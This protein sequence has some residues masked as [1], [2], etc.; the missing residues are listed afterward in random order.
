MGLLI[1]RK[2]ET[3]EP[4]QWAIDFLEKM[5]N[6]QS[7]ERVELHFWERLLKE[8]KRELL[9]DF[10]ALTPSIA[11]FYRG[12][13][14]SDG[15]DGGRILVMKILMGVLP[16]Y[17]A[18][19]CSQRKSAREI[20]CHL[21]I[22]REVI[23]YF[24]SL[25]LAD[26]GDRTFWQKSF[27]AAVKMLL[28]ND[29]SPYLFYRGGQPAFIIAPPYREKTAAC[30]FL[31]PHVIVLYSLPGKNMAKRVHLI[32]HEI[33]HLIFKKYLAD[34]PPPNTFL[35]LLASLKPRDYPELIR[36]SS[37]GLAEI[38]SNLFA[39]AI[40]HETEEG[41]ELFYKIYHKMGKT[42][43]LLRKAFLPDSIFKAL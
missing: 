23:A 21:Q 17:R 18:P 28:H 41:N 42:T 13:G 27:Y 24:K 40:M 8:K 43:L 6:L 3:I 39:L 1:K 38:F 15:L 26:E 12:L 34:K 35:T 11:S 30:Y 5:I 16:S 37:Q 33:G 7:E 31:N 2:I 25:H 22:F 10:Y 14:Y 4:V 36:T 29:Y 32:L 20:A 19:G 9:E